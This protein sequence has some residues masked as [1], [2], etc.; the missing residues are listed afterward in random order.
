[1]NTTIDYNEMIAEQT[2][3][4][5][6]P[7]G[8]GR[9][10]ANGAKR[11]RPETDWKVTELHQMHHKIKDLV[12]L[13]YSNK[14]V[15]EKLNCSPQQVANVKNSPIVKDQ[16]MLMNGAVEAGAVDIQKE[17]ENLQPAALKKLKEVIE[18][19][20]LDGD[21]VGASTVLKECNTIIDRYIGKPTQNIKTQGMVAHLTAD[22]IKEM[23]ERAKEQMAS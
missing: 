17:I 13:G 10:K 20:T 2:S 19:G 3:R 9:F 12:F 18:S 22:E 15:A 8:R 11:V 4:F 5:S 1:M 7:R 14:E 21:R 6:A 23:Q 16:L